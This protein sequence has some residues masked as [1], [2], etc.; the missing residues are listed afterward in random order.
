MGWAR[1][2]WVY[3][4]MTVVRLGEQSRHQGADAP[5]VALH[6]VHQ[7][8]MQVEDN[9]VVP[10]PPRVHLAG[11]RAYD[12]GKTPLDGHMDVLIGQ[13]PRAGAL[14]HLVRN[15][16]QTAQDLVALSGG[17]YADALEHAHVRGRTLYVKGRE[18]I[19]E[20]YRRVQPV[21]ERSRV[22]RVSASPKPPGTLVLVW[23]LAHKMPSRLRA[24]TSSGR[25]HR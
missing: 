6:R 23:L 8:Q 2:R 1:C 12:L 7:I 16:V 5:L 22:G 25:P 13:L 14:L 15:Q 17:Q 20:R 4:G 10:A 24:H 18:H 3:P 21:E 9:L 11:H 19:V